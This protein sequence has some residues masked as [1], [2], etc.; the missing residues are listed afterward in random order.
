MTTQ[1]KVPEMGESVVEATVARWMKAIG[2]SVKAGEALVELETDK[3][4]VEVAAEADGVLSQIAYPAGTDVKI[5]DV[6]GVVEADG[7]G[8]GAGSGPTAASTA[9]PAPTP[10]ASAT[11]P[12]PAE[13]ISA[14]PVAKRVAAEQGV[15]LAAV[16][17]GAGNRIT[18]QDVENFL[19]NQPPPASAQPTVAPSLPPSGEQQS[20]FPH[21]QSATADPRGETRER[22]SRRRRT[23]AERL[24]QAQQT[25]AMLTTFNEIDMSAVMDLRK[26]RN[27]AYEKR[28]GIKA[29]D[30]EFRVV[31]NG[32]HPAAALGI[33]GLDG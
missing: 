8:Q 9:A 33:D 16:S 22:L 4:N 18:K 32:E 17:S 23:I 25:A 6:L 10:D 24:V 3:V 19:R 5:G 2:D 12:A 14:T 13:E 1:I 11:P 21:L 30:R 20:P 7:A 31:R 15:D 27:D 26:R 28:H 29:R